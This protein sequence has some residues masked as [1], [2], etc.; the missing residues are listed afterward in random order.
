MA[1]FRE[2][3]KG[4]NKNDEGVPLSY[5]G[6]KFHRVVKDFMIQG[7][8]F[9]EGDGT[10]GLSIYGESFADENFLLK[11]SQ[12]MLL[13]M[14]NAGPDSNGSQFFITTAPAPHLDG[15]HVVFGKVLTGKDIVRDIEHLETDSRDVPRVLVEIVDSGLF[16]FNDPLPPLDDGT[17]DDYERYL[18]DDPRVDINNPESVFAA[19]RAVKE[20][21]NRLFA[22]GDM[23]KAYAKYKK[24]SEHLTQYF[25]D[26]LSEDDL[27]TLVTLKASVYLNLS[28]AA[29]KTSRGAEAAKAADEVLQLDDVTDKDYT[30]ALYRRGTGYLLAKNE[31]WALRD[32]QEALAR[33]PGDAAIL[34][35]IEQAKAASAKRREAERARFQRAFAK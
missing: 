24:A 3:C 21:G 29:I 10:G 30:R 18:V 5:K 13:S 7:G 27:Q 22:A 14:A 8:D 25:P 20:I 28:L 11:H 32:L 33:S 35:Q 19:V 16:P 4:E 17:G 31:E 15:K 6:S 2:L 26:D 34:Y 9:T 23:E 1:N 12:P